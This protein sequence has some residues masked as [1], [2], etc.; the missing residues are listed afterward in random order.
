MDLFYRTFNGPLLWLYLFHTASHHPL[1]PRARDPPK[2]F[3][4]T[5]PHPG[6]QQAGSFPPPGLSSPVNLFS[7][8]QEVSLFLVLGCWNPRTHLHLQESPVPTPRPWHCFSH[9]RSSP[10]LN[11]STEPGPRSRVET[12][13]G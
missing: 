11:G 4:M 12:G 1:H 5:L 9:W 8:G 7:V 6:T 13:Q 3:Q 2:P 10:P